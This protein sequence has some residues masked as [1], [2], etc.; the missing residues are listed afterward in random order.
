MR[1]QVAPPGTTPKSPETR[2]R[3]SR[4]ALWLAG[5][6]LA[7]VAA[8]AVATALGS[9]TIP[10]PAVLRVLGRSAVGLPP[11]PGDQV[12]TTIILQVRLP[13]VLLAG[14]VGLGL[15]TA[16]AVMQGLFRNPLADP[17]MLG[18]SSGGA[19][20]AVVAIYLGLAGERLWVVPTCAFAGATLSAFLVY[21]LAVVQGRTPLALL[22]LTGLALSSLLA[23][24]TTFLLTISQEFVLREIVYWLMGS[25]D[26]RGWRHLAVTVGPVAVGTLALA[27]YGREL[28]L[29]LLGEEVAQAG[30]LA[31]EGRKRW[32]LVLVSLVT[33]T[34]VAVSGTIS[35]VGVIVPHLMRLLV[36]PDHRLLLPASALA[37]ATF[38]ILADL[39]ARVAVR[40][41]EL[42]LG[43]VTAFVGV[44]F[45]LYLLR[46]TRR[47]ALGL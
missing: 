32:L 20:G 27:G 5:L 17:G 41:A 8:V 46:R 6:A 16:G 7:V 2:P 42:H 19:L 21:R 44:P 11:L 28:N 37:G 26:G 14:L 45:F 43:V 33:G 9:A 4:A 31:V 40:P 34:V 15:A 36:G 13:R 30:G 35:F 22:L 47:E 12:W 1:Q 29:L 10:L 24:A 23:S 18:V 25:L 3:R 38:L 39:V